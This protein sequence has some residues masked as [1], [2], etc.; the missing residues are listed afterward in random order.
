MATY[1]ITT[2]RRPPKQGEQC[3]VGPFAG[4]AGKDPVIVPARA[5]F[6]EWWLAEVIVD[7][8][9]LEEG[10]SLALYGEKYPHPEDATIEKVLSTQR[11]R[12]R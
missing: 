10:E 2:E 7:L 6:P 1:V 8:Y 5:N 12:R 9:E 4:Q 11:S 3:V